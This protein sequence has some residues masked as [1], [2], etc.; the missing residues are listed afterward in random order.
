MSDIDEIT[1]FVFQMNGD[2]KAD[3]FSESDDEYVVK[4]VV[5]MKGDIF[6]QGDFVP[7][8]VIKAAG[9]SANPTQIHDLNHQGTGYPMPNGQMVPSDISYIVGYQDNIHVNEQ[10]KSLLVDVHIQKDAPMANSWKSYYDISA[11]AGRMP[12][13]SAFGF[14][15]MTLVKA[16]N[17]PVD[18]ASFGLK[19]HETVVS[20]TYM[21][22]V[23][24]STVYRGACNDKDGCG[25]PIKACEDMHQDLPDTHKEDK[26]RVAHLKERIKLFGGK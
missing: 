4:G 10:E 25:M 18:Y 13:V 15:R 19:G 12:N 23:A 17:L 14:K 24:G 3:G 7:W 8:D 21:D 20:L 16:K 5:L 1:P 2:T 26:V 9:M 22:L 11:K 6:Y